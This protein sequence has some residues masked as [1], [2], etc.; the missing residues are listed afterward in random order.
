MELE[1]SEP[2]DDGELPLSLAQR[3]IWLDQCA[4]PDSPHLNIGGGGFLIGPLD[5]ARFRESLR[6]LVAESEALR[7]APTRGGRQRLVAEHEPEFEVIDFRAAPDPT[8]AVREWRQARM[9]ELFALDSRPPWRFAL[10]LCGEALHGVMI[11]F[12]HLVMDGWGTSIVIRRWSEIYNALGD[13]DARPIRER[14]SYL[15]FIGESNAYRKSEAFARDREFWLDRFPSLPDPLFD[16]PARGEEPRAL[17]LAYLETHRI[18]RTE[19]DETI[20]ALS[21]HRPTAFAAFLAAVAIYFART[22]RREEIVIGV[23]HLNRGS[24]RYRLTPGMFAGVFPLRLAVP[25]DVGLGAM[26]AGIAGS[27]RAALRHSGYPLSELGRQLHLMRHGREGIF[28]VLLSFERQDYTVRFGEARPIESRQFF[29]GIARYPLGIT[30]CEFNQEQ[31][32]E[33]VIEGS[34]AYFANGDMALLGRRL[35]HLV[36]AIATMPETT[37]GALD[38]LP[39]EERS[40]ILDDLHRNV[41]SHQSTVPFITQFEHQASLRPQATALLCQYGSMS[42]ET[43]DRRANRLAHQ[44]VAAGAERD[45]VVAVAVSRSPE[46]VIAVLA[47]AKSGAAFLPLDVDAPIA[48]IAVILAESGAV[49][50]L[51]QEHNWERLSPLHPRSLIAK[52]SSHSQD[53]ATQAPARPSPNDLAYVLF[54]S[55]STGRPKGVMVE[56]AALSRRLGWLSRAWAVEWRDRSA[57]ATQLTFDPSLIELLLPLVNGASVALPPP[58]RVLPETL[59]NF[60]V[61][62]GVTIMAFVPYT[63][64]RFLAA[65]GNRPGLRLRVACCG[66]EVLSP[67]LASRFVRTTGARLCNV[68]GPTEATIFA[69]TWDCTSNPSDTPLPIGRPIDDTRIYVLDDRL[70][71]MPFGIVGDVYIGGGALARGYLRRPDL[72]AQAYLD[73]PY[74]SGERIYRTGDR[75]WLAGDGNLHFA[76]RADRQVKLRG[77][78][79]ELGEIESALLSIAGVEQ[80]AVKRIER[81]SEPMLHAWI[82]VDA[83]LDAGGVREAL[84]SILPDYM[85]PGGITVLDRLPTTVSE[86][87][88]YEAL[89]EPHEAR[90]N[91]LPRGPGSPLERDLVALWEEVLSRKPIGVHDNFF[92]L[93]GDSLAA[94][95]ILAGIDHLTG[96]RASLHVLAE[97]PT[98]ARL[99]TTLVDE[100]DCARAMIHLSSDSS[101]TPL[102]IA[103]SGHGDSLR[104]QRLAQSL[105]GAYDVHMLQPPDAVELRSIDDLASLYA[106]RIMAQGDAPGFL[107]G[108]SIG[109]ITALKTCCLLR[110]RGAPPRGLVLIDTIFPGRLVGV[111]TFWKQ[112]GWLVRTLHVQDLSVNGRRIGALFEDSGLVGQVMALRGHRPAPYDGPALL[113]RSSGLSSW[114]RWLFQSWRRLFGNRL[115]ERQVSGLHGSIFENGTISELAGAISSGLDET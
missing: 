50:L 5:H 111:A 95:A 23:P 26:T 40:A 61:T 96:R 4:W 45:R 13:A 12:H 97:N 87:I 11:Q 27:L 107:A 114:D 110:E 37:A 15:D 85:L 69:T 18:P 67:E 60:S 22:Q 16:R 73:D 74:R 79:I 25:A 30:V 88:D 56:H 31:D 106:D 24:K 43:L 113:I 89:A 41:A 49:A 78:R 86:K 48:R 62:H 77:Y 1:G 103:A 44:L 20:L 75:G 101:G 21:R 33:I 104:L 83:G 54:T 3:E 81:N 91:S 8:G 105:G 59:V 51:I 93:G 57:Q 2:I 58:G 63:L 72:T 14:T 100:R 82:A 108:F 38:V 90:W 109:G 68:Y 66:G 102:Y 9:K 35:W 6:R 39:P 98:V 52:A 80:A 34:S 32:V 94:I 29:S 99:A 10:L 36:R 42:Y 115:R 46:M 47:V 64:S 28:D 7:L 76:G 55:G 70:Q 53:L 65:A 84:R 71:P 92:D 19:Y 112:L 17:P